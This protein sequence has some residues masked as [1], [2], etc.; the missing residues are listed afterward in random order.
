MTNQLRIRL[1][2]ACEFAHEF[3]G[4]AFGNRTEVLN[5]IGLGQTNA[6]VGN[7]QGFCSFIE[8][9]LDAQIGIGL[10]QLRLIQT[11]KTQFVTGI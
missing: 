7:R 3:F 8:G 4:T 6:V 1:L 9:D 2:L 10:V 11:L 5:R